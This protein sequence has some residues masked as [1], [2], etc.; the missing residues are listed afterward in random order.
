M[1]IECPDRGLASVRL[2]NLKHGVPQCGCDGP[3]R[4]YST[5]AC[6]RRLI[7]DLRYLNTDSVVGRSQRTN[8]MGKAGNLEGASYV[9]ALVCKRLYP[10]LCRRAA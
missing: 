9:D 1:H 10:S 8:D 3:V 4:V 6:Y 7:E 5:V 2:A